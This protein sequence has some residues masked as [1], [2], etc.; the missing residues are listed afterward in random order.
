MPIKL[1]FI[2]NVSLKWSSKL[3]RMLCFLIWVV[4][5]YLWLLLSNVGDIAKLITLSLLTIKSAF[6]RIVLYFSLWGHVRSSPW[7]SYVHGVFFAYVILTLEGIYAC[8]HGYSMASD[9][10]MQFAVRYII[11]IAESKEN[12]TYEIIFIL[13]HFEL[14][15]RGEISLR[16]VYIVCRIYD[17]FRKINTILFDRAEI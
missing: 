5:I 11:F 13:L 4:F 17:D 12:E 9:L 1:F 6:L 15:V 8:K 7:L 2:N 10:P 16:I 14:H 3:R